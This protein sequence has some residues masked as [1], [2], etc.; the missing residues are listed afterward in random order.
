MRP[1]DYCLTYDCSVI[2][3]SQVNISAPRVGES[4]DCLPQIIRQGRSVCIATALKFSSFTFVDIKL[5]HD[6]L[7]LLFP[8]LVLGLLG[9]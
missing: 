6:L 8:L 9:D 1:A 5:L 7:P 3:H 2:S 4:A